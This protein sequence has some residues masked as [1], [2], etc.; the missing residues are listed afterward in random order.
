MLFGFQPGTGLVVALLVEDLHH[1]DVVVSDHLLNVVL[2]LLN[3]SLK[4]VARGELPAE[5]TLLS[6]SHDAELV[7]LLRAAPLEE[8]LELILGSFETSLK[9]D[10]LR[11]RLEILL[12]DGNILELGR[13]GWQSRVHDLPV[14]PEVVL[15]NGGTNHALALE[16]F[17]ELWAL[18]AVDRARRRRGEQPR[19]PAVL[20][21]GTRIDD[22]L[23]NL[24]EEVLQ[25]STEVM[26]IESASVHGRVTRS[27]VLHDNE[28]LRLPQ[29]LL[30]TLIASLDCGQLLLPLGI[31]GLLEVPLATV[32]LTAGL[33]VQLAITLQVRHVHLVGVV[34][35]RGASVGRDRVP[36]APQSSMTKE[37]GRVLAL[38][39]GQEPLVRS[40]CDAI[41]LAVKNPD[42]G[43][44]ALIDV[45]VVADI[46]VGWR[47]IGQLIVSDVSV[48]DDP[49]LAVTVTE[50]G[51][52]DRTGPVFLG[53]HQRTLSIR[54]DGPG[55][56]LRHLQVLE[57]LVDEHGGKGS[58]TV[59]HRP[60]ILPVA[61][62][63]G[64]TELLVHNEEV[65]D[66]LALEPVVVLGEL[67]HLVPQIVLHLIHFLD[68]KVASSLLVSVTLAAEQLVVLL[69]VLSIQLVDVVVQPLT[70]HNVRVLAFV[71]ASPAEPRMSHEAGDVFLAL[72][73][74]FE[75][76][77]GGLPRGVVLAHDRAILLLEDTDVASVR[78]I[79]VHLGVDHLVR[80][81]EPI[82]DQRPADQNLALLIL[83]GTSRTVDDVV[84]LTV[85]KMHRSFH[86]SRSLD[87]IIERPIGHLVD[88]LLHAVRV[89][90][91]S[92]VKFRLLLV[93]S[94]GKP[95]FEN[96]L[97]TFA[98]VEAEE[99]LMVLLD[100]SLP[101]LHEL[102]FSVLLAR[103]GFLVVLLNLRLDILSHQLVD[104]VLLVKVVSL[105]VTR[106]A[107]ARV[108]EVLD[109]GVRHEADLHAVL[110]LVVDKLLV[111]LASSTIVGRIQLNHLQLGVLLAQVLHDSDEGVLGVR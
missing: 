44:V 75:G 25:G 56:V 82:L 89:L 26:R 47:N 103:F 61:I 73:S 94:G 74:T 67:Q 102:D 39:A 37:A 5:A 83:Q 11:V 76:H 23:N 34:V 24:R 53:A 3:I 20:V 19:P 99:L 32:S 69:S 97:G 18:R 45:L 9:V 48:R 59:L 7:L 84:P 10:E 91:K 95:I 66:L 70:G 98:L 68:S 111:L 13:G 64:T 78:R 93:H 46:L 1:L 40:K 8:C 51:A 60:M 79:G 28:M 31:V 86:D 62:V 17:R 96:Q 85:H 42:D 21:D 22:F 107:R 49:A 38:S 72:P 81:V 27:A 71:A 58:E 106:D 4:V 87:P 110:H 57:D 50:H 108:H 36:P 77:H 88:C 12:H 105:G 29:V 43:L 16:V 15:L 90:R 100:L 65:D 6:V 92:K 63:N 41:V 14:S 101:V 54:L 35:L 30:L 33:V 2:L 55:E 52:A 80:R 109:R 104:V